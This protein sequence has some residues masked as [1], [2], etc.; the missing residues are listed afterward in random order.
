VAEQG[1]AGAAVHLPLDHLGF[2]VHSLGAPVVV[3][4]RERGRGGLDVQLK[5]A[6]E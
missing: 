4:H 5:A 3:R 6:G 2:R 1:E